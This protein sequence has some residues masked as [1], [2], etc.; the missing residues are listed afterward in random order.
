MVNK[1]TYKNKIYSQN[2]KKITL[3]YLILS[4]IMKLKKYNNNNN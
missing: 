1:M 4:M 2:N 3:I